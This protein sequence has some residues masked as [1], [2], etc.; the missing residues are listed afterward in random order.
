[1]R[2]ATR[3]TLG[4]GDFALSVNP[5]LVVMGPSGSVNTMVSSTSTNGLNE[6]IALTCTGS[7]AGAI[8]SQT[9]TIGAN[10][11]T[12]AL[13]L[14]GSGLVA[15]DYPFQITGHTNL[16]SHTIPAILRV[17]DYSAAL[18]STVATLSAGQSATFFLTLNSINH[19]TNNINLFCQSPDAKLGCMLSQSSLTLTDGGTTAVTLTVTSSQTSGSISGPS[20][21][22][23]PAGLLAFA[24]PIAFLLVIT[25]GRRQKRVAGLVVCFLAIASWVACGGGGSVASGGGIGG[26]GSGGGTPSPQTVTISVSAVGD[27]RFFDQSNNKTVGPIVITLH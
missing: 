1:M 16:A 27:Y 17:E 4:I 15:N 6:G 26:G 2:Q 20:P 19:Y 3:L 7:P 23:Y 8:C 24:G 25:R 13:S 9:Y 22:L 10:G 14:G 5:A 12:G 18:D 21:H 11:E